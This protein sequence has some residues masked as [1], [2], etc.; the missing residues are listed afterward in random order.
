MRSWSPFGY[1]VLAVTPL[2]VVWLAAAVISVAST[3]LGIVPRIPLVERIV[4]AGAVV[5]TALGACLLVYR[6]DEAI[7]ARLS[8]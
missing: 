5:A 2:Y 7:R 8:A 6:V 4:F 1:L 3:H